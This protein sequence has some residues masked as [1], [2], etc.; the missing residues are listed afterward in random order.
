MQLQ[1]TWKIEAERNGVAT[2]SFIFQ[3]C[4]IETFV[5]LKFIVMQYTA[6]FLRGMLFIA[7]AYSS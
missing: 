7:L 1:I 5:T 4:Y 3:I 6:V 2:A